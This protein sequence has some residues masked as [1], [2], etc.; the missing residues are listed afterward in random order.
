MSPAF[1]SALPRAQR[2]PALVAALLI[3]FVILDMVLLFADAGEVALI[4]LPV[5][6]GAICTTVV[7]LRSAV[8]GLVFLAIATESPG[9]AGGLWKSPFHL[10]G[11]LLHANLNQTV[12]IPALRI[13]GIDVLVL[14]LFAIGAVRRARKNPLELEERVGAPAP[15]R[16]AALLSLLTVAVIA[17]LGLATGGVLE[18]IYWQTHQFVMVPVLFFLFIATLRGPADHRAIGRTYLA[19]AC[20]KACLA[21]Y[22]GLTVFLP[23]GRHL[24]TTTSHGDSILFVCASALLIARLVERPDRRSVLINLLLLPLFFFA[25][26][27][28]GRRLAW[29]ELA[30]VLLCFFMLSPWRPLKRAVARAVVVSIPLIAVYLVAGWNSGSRIFAPVETVRSIVVS[31]TDRSTLERDVENFNLLW[32]VRAHPLLGIGYGHGYIEKVRGDDISKVFPQYRYIPHNSLLGVWAFTGLVG[33]TALWMVIALGVFFAVRGYR[34]AH[35]WRDRAAGLAVVAVVV[36]YLVQCYGDM[37]FVSW[38]GAFTL[39]LALCVAGKLAVSAGAW[40]A[41]LPRAVEASA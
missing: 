13:T 33:F 14:V 25:M 15:L 32:T 30:G 38:T 34:H 21:I 23:D 31:K 22:V 6:L 40:P 19:A 16:R 7:P 18:Q 2:T 26:Q 5:E 28:N 29:V 37:G 24:A 36:V 35:E 3:S 9:D 41:A 17:L 20:V 39:S 11:T 1:A 27:Q 8:L 4:L 10:L 12:P